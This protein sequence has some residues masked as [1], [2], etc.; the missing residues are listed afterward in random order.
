[1]P[2]RLAARH[3]PGRSVLTLTAPTLV[4]VAYG[5]AVIAVS[6][7]TGSPCTVLPIGAAVAALLG[8]IA[9]L[10]TRRHSEREFAA[11]AAVTTTVVSATSSLTL[12]VFAFT[13]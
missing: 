3:A 9:V 2:E 4:A 13:T 8:L 5:R 6:R 12:L 7:Q 10:V 11:L 1:M